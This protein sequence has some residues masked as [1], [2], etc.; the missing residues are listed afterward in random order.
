MKWYLAA[1]LILIA[2]LVLQSGLLAY[3]M[4]VLF[5]VLLISRFLARQWLQNLAAQRLCPHH[6]AEIGDKVEVTVH[7]RNAGWF[8]VPWVVL[9][10]MLSATAISPRSPRLR[11][12]GKRLAVR[13]I[14]TR[15]ETELRYTI[16]CLMRG[17][18]QVG[19]LVMETGDLFGLHRRFRVGAD[20][21][22]LLVYPRTVLLQGYD[23]MS[24][25]PI[26][27]VR[28]THRLYEDPTRV[29]GVRPYEAVDP[30]NRVHWRATARTDRKSG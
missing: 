24:R 23:I 5:A 21:H 29:S 16:E 25:R 2:A 4:Y 13:A 10:D 17:Y 22:F 15:G 8:G 7:V 26:G 27:D 28:M 3:A 30:L 9:E 20:P 12:K 6:E 18:Y 19:P 1:A 14:R 11:A